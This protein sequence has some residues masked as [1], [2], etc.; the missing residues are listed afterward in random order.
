MTRVSAVFLIGAVVASGIPDGEALALGCP[1]GVV[2]AAHART[3]DHV[4]SET[5]EAAQDII[6]ALREQT[7]QTSSHIDRQVEAARRIADGSAQNDA[8]R[9]RDGFRAAAESGRFDPNPDYCL[10]IDMAEESLGV[11]PPDIL[12]AT[13]VADDVTAWTLGGDPAVRANGVRMAVYL[14]AEHQ[15]L[16][17]IGGVADPTTDWTVVSGTPTAPLADAAV[18]KAVARLIA[19]TITPF[20]PAPLSAEAQ[21]T[22]AG[23]SEAAI[24]RA[25]DA[26][27][28]AAMNAIAP[29]LDLATPDEPSAAYRA[30][31]NRARYRE[32]IPEQISELQRLDIRTMAYFA[33]R[34]EALEMRH[35][36]TEQA[37]LQ[38]LIDVAS[39]QA[40]IDY[41]R[42][43]QDMRTAILLAAM[44]GIMTDGARTDLPPR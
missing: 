13:A 8:M 10:L 44:L 24:R 6:R 27:D 29:A 36:K 43:N 9:M 28:Q 19:N 41:L 12:A 15:A 38:D 7:R 32:A 31:A 23:L 11:P 40:R 22:P 20:P 33:P 37:L 5:T 2:G 1:C 42:L 26:R 18:R 3:R 17:G 16:A 25:A 39:L 35:G 34:T 4:S 14:E 30:L 21:E